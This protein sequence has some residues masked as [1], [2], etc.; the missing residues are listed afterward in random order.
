MTAPGADLARRI[1]RLRRHLQDQGLGTVLLM[2][3]EH[4]RYFAGTHA[5]GLPAALV[6]TRDAA[7]LIAAGGQADPEALRTLGVDLAAYRGYDAGRLVD[8][9]A[10][11]FETL[12]ATVRHHGVRG[13]LGVEASHVPQAT[14]Q[15]IP[16]AAPQDVTRDLAGW[17][18]IKD[19]REQAVIR[20][21]VAMLDDAFAAVQSVLRPG[22]TERDIL[23]AAHHR[24][25]DHVDEPLTLHGNLASGPRTA[26]DN[27]RAARREIQSGDLV[28]V[29]LYPILD[30]YAADCT[31]TFV[32]G[33]STALQRER[34][35]ALE[36]A[37]A[38]AEARLR[39]GTD[40]AVIDGAIR[41]ALRATTPA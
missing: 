3:P 9:P 19:E 6:V 39:P 2:R 41:D 8:R 40:V 24:L 11:L 35:S 23:A 34:H 15:G 13:R 20:A 10:R 14:V 33:P 36:T 1:V 7:V 37:L 18:A 38:A 28:L 30:G 25:L 22:L 27:P 17:R 32:A 12:D 4:L 16:D 21:R 29:D 5:G 31:R 26:M